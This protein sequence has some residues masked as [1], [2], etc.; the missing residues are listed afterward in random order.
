[1]LSNN[2]IKEKTNII[3]NHFKVGN[4]E[5]VISLSNKL[6]KELPNHEYLLNMIGMSHHRLNQ[7]EKAE[8]IF[9]KAINRNKANVI[10]RLNYSMVLKSQERISD[11]ILELENIIEREPNYIPA[12]NNLANLKKDN[13][14][15]NDAIELFKKLINLNPKIATAHYNLSICYQQIRE[16]EKSIKHAKLASDL[17]ENLT[18]SDQTISMLT[19]Y[20]TNDSINHFK[21]IN[22]KIN[23]NKIKQESL[24]PLFFA[25]GK[26]Y[27]DKE[28]YENAFKYYSKANSNYREINQS[29]FY[30][31]REEYLKIKDYFESDNKIQLNSKIT[32]NHKFIFICGMP[33]S[34][35]TLLEQIISTSENTQSLGETNYFNK[36]IKKH[37]KFNEE[38]IRNSFNECLK[39]KDNL[40]L[41][42]YV[43]YIKRYNLNQNIITDKS[44]LNFK[45]IGFL[46][47]FLPN[48]KVIILERDFKNNFLS[49]FKNYLPSL[50]W[51]FDREEIEKFHQLFLDYVQ[52]WEKMCPSFIHRVKYEELIENPEVITKKLFSFCELDWSENVLN[53]H[54]L[55]KSPIR[56]ASNNQADKPIYKSSLDKY[57][58]FQK[59]FE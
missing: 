28:D 4:F 30:L 34:G 8:D 43:S 52:L 5:N 7:L 9:V 21:T 58:K 16:K 24:T 42:T 29:K 14:E 25:L 53:Y 11:A 10:L 35:T 57:S 59:F 18:I 31:E 49:I 45:Y 19:N 20:K 36:A 50:H 41:D 55:N 2:E 47:T 17:D 54:Q 56:T 38:S 44:L 32:N 40:I 23:S 39:N 1:M 51:T 6:L 46:K 12:I 48:S 13:G 26:A 33:R 15:F 37:I 22:D 27:E 3:L